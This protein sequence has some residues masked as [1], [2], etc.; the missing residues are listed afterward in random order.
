VKT[1]PQALHPRSRISTY[2]A[3]KNST[4]GS[5]QSIFA[6]ETKRFHPLGDLAVIRVARLFRS[7]QASAPQHL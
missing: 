6:N 7:E 3:A 2:G 4:A 1:V 5:G